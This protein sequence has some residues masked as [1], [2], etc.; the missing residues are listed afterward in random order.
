MASGPL[1]SFATTTPSIMS[2]STAGQGRPASCTEIVALPSRWRRMVRSNPGKRGGLRNAGITRP[3]AR[4]ASPNARAAVAKLTALPDVPDREEEKA[5]SVIDSIFPRGCDTRDYGEAMA[6]DGLTRPELNPAQQQV[7]DLLGAPADERPTFDAELRHQLRA[8]LEA[9]VAHLG[10]DLDPDDP[11][12]ISKH[13]LG[14]VHGCEVRLLAEEK[15]GFAWSVATARG[16]IAHKAIEL[17]INWKGEP[18]PAELVDETIARQ[19]NAGDSLAEFLQQASEFELTELRAE[20]LDRVTKFAES[21]PPLSSR[22]RPV[23]ESRARVELADGRIILS[24]KVDLSLGQ[25]RGTTAGKVLIDLKTGGP[26]PVHT[27]DLR[28]YALLE[29]IR[30][31]VPPRLVATYYLD[32][33]VARTEAVTEGVLHAT[34]ARV[35]DGIERLVGLAHGTVEPVLRPG[36]ACRWCVALADCDAGRTHLADSSY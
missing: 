15:A 25:A 24:G 31:G 32:S 2:A 16:T 26:A 30:L 9:A 17:S 21:F 10:P 20:A 19:A 29:T 33:G 13:Q 6:T 18:V 12:F 34:V 22:W 28:F 23:T 11:I 27:D 35:T 4:A 14:M 1:R 3:L 8:E 7:L 36:P 5:R